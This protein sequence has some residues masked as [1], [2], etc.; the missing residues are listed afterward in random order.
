M[1]ASELIRL[2][3]ERVTRLALVDTVARPDTPQRKAFRH[4]ANIAVGMSG[5][6]RRLARYNLGSLIH[7]SAAEDVRDELVAMSVRV[8]S[9]TCI[10][11]N[12]AVMA[13]G[14]QR[15]LLPGI[16]VPTAV[17]V[18]QEDQMTPF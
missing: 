8:G 3:P 12:R 15:K 4:L 16:A 6:F 7:P 11:Q 14:D 10:R 1:V 18:G 9:R 2:A 17:I 5:D 13:Q